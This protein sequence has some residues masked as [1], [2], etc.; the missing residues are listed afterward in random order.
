MRQAGS[1][2]ETEGINVSIF[3]V[4]SNE[5]KELVMVYCL[6]PLL[7]FNGGQVLDLAHYRKLSSARRLVLPARRRVGRAKNRRNIS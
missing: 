4:L 1:L 2:H 3:P 7:I 5:G 6:F